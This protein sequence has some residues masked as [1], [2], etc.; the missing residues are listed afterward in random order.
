LIEK[1]NLSLIKIAVERG[2][3]DSTNPAWP[4]L[5]PDEIRAITAEA[6]GKGRLVAAHVTGASEMREALEAGVDIAAHAP[7]TPPPDS[8]LREAADRGMI[9]IST[10]QCWMAEKQQYAETA[11]ANA[12]RFHQ[13]GGRLAIGTDYPFV[14]NS[15]PLVEFDWLSKAGMSSRDL[16]YAATHESAAAIGRSA[17]LGTL[18]P[19]K[20]ADLIVVQGDPLADW[21]AMANVTLVMLDGRVVKDV[22]ASVGAVA[23]VGVGGR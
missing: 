10:V 11:A 15:M 6:H 17:D 8:I 16:I 1:E 18:E 2:F 23:G 20:I 9:M 22:G 21:H 14:P 4:I 3:D 7:V 12:V 13:L 5:S 19:G